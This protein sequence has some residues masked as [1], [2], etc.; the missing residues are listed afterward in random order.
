MSILFDRALY[1]IPKHF[2]NIFSTLHLFLFVVHLP[3][4]L[5][6][7]SQSVNRSVREFTANRQVL[8]K[9]FKVVCLWAIEIL[10][11]SLTRMSLSPAYNCRTNPDG[12][13]YL[14][15]INYKKLLTLHLSKQ[16]EHSPRVETYSLLYDW[17]NGQMVRLFGSFPISG[18]A[19]WTLEAKYFVVSSDRYQ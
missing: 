8:L 18:S 12:G 11:L 14:S 4:T 1:L 16:D 6:F 10:Y 2:W 3:T 7:R 15:I 13:T 5:A 19:P 17:S 9:G